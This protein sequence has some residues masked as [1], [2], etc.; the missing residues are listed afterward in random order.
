MNYSIRSLNICYNDIS[1]SSVKISK[2]SCVPRLIVKESPSV[3]TVI[4]LVSEEDSTLAPAITWVFSVACTVG[5]GISPKLLAPN[6][7]NKLSKG[8]ICGC[9]HCKWSRCSSGT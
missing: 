6:S 7:V 3:V 4:P 8:G 2:G 5:I 1:C 9:K